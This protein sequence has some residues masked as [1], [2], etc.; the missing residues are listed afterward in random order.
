MLSILQK[1][2]KSSKVFIYK[3]FNTQSKRVLKKIKNAM[4]KRR[5]MEIMRFVAK[6]SWNLKVQDILWSWKLVQI[7]KISGHQG[8]LQFFWNGKH[9]SRENYK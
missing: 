7:M 2:L 9:L 1:H 4:L 3:N 5:W 8:T 6:F